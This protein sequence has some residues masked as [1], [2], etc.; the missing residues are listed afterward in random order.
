MENSTPP[1]GGQSRPHAAASP[2]WVIGPYGQPL[3]E[4]DLPTP[5]CRYWTPRRKAEV[6]AAVVGGL[7]SVDEVFERY[8]LTVEEFAGW[9]RAVDRF[10]LSGLKQTRLQRY[11]D[12]QDRSQRFGWAAN[13]VVLN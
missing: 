6:V 8:Q 5:G 2:S 10:G 1:L 13:A 7:L 9:Q 3:T 12:L 4:D 11:R